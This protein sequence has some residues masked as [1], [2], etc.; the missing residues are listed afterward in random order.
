MAG[1]RLR[2]YQEE[3]LNR[4]MNGCILN[5]GVGSGKSRTALAYYYVLNGG[6]VNTPDYVP[7]K[8]KPASL[9]IITTARKRDTLEWEGELTNFIMTA[10]KTISR[11]KH[12]IVIDSWNNI[13]KYTDVKNAFFIFDEQ[14]VIGY[15]SWTKSFLK[16]TAKNE[17]I[18]LSATPGDTWSD[19]IPVFIAN[20]YYKNKT[21]FLR[22]H[23][24]FSRYTKYPKI[25]K[26]INEGRLIRLRKHLLI[27]MDFERTTVPHHNYITTE[28][29]RFAYNKIATDRWNL[30]TNK[31]IK[32]AGEFCFTLQKLV[33]SDPSRLVAIMEILYKHP[34]AIIFYSYDYELDLLRKLFSKEYRIA[35][36]N[37]DKDDPLPTGDEPWL[38]LVDET[39]AMSEWNGH[40][41]EPIPETEKWAYLVQYISGSEGWN[42]VETDTII[43]YSQNY[44]YRIMLQASGRIDRMNTPFTD[45]YYYHLRSNSKIDLAIRDAQKRKKK[46]NE[47]GFA[48]IFDKSTEEVL[49][50]G[51][52]IKR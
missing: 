42:C 30:Y 35:E 41:H 27:N 36:K 37:K 1:V 3:A 20:G 9:Y 16:I 34:K 22:K 51:E 43:F 2:D 38:Y 45:L 4:M 19:Y 12:D 31:P 17:W 5:G 24:V 40:K 23:A 11:Y 48:P 13:G 7:M 14:R 18:L 33:N 50:I 29:D 44:S 26:Y 15:G 39:Y 49:E 47:R 46:F 10:D 8:T 32:N 6:E 28:Y 25:E 21:D 52:V